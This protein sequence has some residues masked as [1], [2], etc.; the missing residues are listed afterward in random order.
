MEN[1]M[2]CTL[3]VN[4]MSLA[5]EERFKWKPQWWCFSICILIDQLRY[6]V[7]I[8]D[9][10]H[11]QKGYARCPYS[12]ITCLKSNE[13]IFYEMKIQ[14]TFI[15]VHPM[16]TRIWELPI[17]YNVQFNYNIITSLL[18]LPFLSEVIR[19][20]TTSKAKDR[21]E[22]NHPRA[23]NMNGKSRFNVDN[24]LKSPVIRVFPFFFF[25]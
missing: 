11:W 21:R 24:G 17:L 9:L 6:D 8:Q 16:C 15:I 12:S 23:T 7:R 5:R 14:V 18:R 19:F 2:G 3:Y 13:G 20:F 10:W 22:I 4:V 25:P 1:A